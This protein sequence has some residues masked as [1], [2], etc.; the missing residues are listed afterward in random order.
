M[1][2]ISSRNSVPPSASRTR[3]GAPPRRAPVNAPSAWPNSSASTRRLRQCGAVDRHERAAPAARCVGVA[4][5]LLLAGAG[6]AADQ[7]RQPAQRRRPPPVAPPPPRPGRRRRSVRRGDG[8]AARRTGIGARHAAQ[9]LRRRGE[10]AADAVLQQQPYPA[11]ARIQQGRE[12]VRN[13]SS[14]RRPGQGRQALQQEAR[15]RIGCRAPVRPDRPRAARRSSVCRYSA[16]LW[17]AITKSCGDAR[18]RARSRSASPPCATSACVCCCRDRQSEEASSTPAS[19]PSGAEHRRRGAGEAAVTGRRSAPA[20][21]RDRPA[22]RGDRAERIGA[23]AALGPHRAGPDAAASARSAL[24]LGSAMRVQQHSVGVGE[25]DHEV[26]CR[27][28]GDT[29]CAS[30]PSPDAR[31]RSQPLAALPCSAVRSATTHRRRPAAGRARRRGSAPSSRRSRQ[32]SS[33]PAAAPRS[34]STTA[35]VGETRLLPTRIRFLLASRFA[36]A[37]CAN[38]A[39]SCAAPV[40]KTRWPRLFRNGTVRRNALPTD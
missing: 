25:G 24:K 26:A 32:G 31:T 27:R 22:G 34:S 40:P 12:R 4:R 28:S 29:G 19:P 2:P 8:A 13:R 14:K 6:L 3:P 15:L 23:A 10:G 33:L 35:R 9:V 1:S 39:R 11:R 21:H 20:V 7:E 16:R 36:A 17:N 18:G 30:R 37:A 38:S 5:E